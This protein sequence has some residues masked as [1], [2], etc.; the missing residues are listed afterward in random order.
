M[1]TMFNDLMNLS[2]EEIDNSKVEFNTKAGHE[3]EYFI[4]R[5]IR[6]SDDEKSAGICFDC[7]YWKWERPGQIVFSFIR[8]A[9]DK[10]LFVSAARIIKGWDGDNK[11]VEVISECER[12]FG[13]LLVHCNKFPLNYVFNLK[14]YIDEMV[15]EEIANSLEYFNTYG[16]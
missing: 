10:W 8:I 13:R 11:K 7:S 4:D 6:H 1:P 16:K 9:K 3:G 14:R 2:P 5:W 15:V 12:Y